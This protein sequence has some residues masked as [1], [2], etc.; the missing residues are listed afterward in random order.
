MKVLFLLLGVLTLAS[1]QSNYASQG[2]SVEYNNEGLP[3]ST[4]LDGRVTKLE[5]LSPVIFLN[6]TKA[7][8]NCAAGE[9]EVTLIIY[10]TSL[11]LNAFD[12][13]T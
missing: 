7:F 13:S 11:L 3:D 1:G 12:I 8:L 6:R 10:F 4:V 5:D 9:M 2:N